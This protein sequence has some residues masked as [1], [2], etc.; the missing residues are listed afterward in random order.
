VSQE[1]DQDRSEQA[2]PHKLEEARKRGQVARSGD[3]SSFAVLVVAMLA[4]QALAEPALQGLAA[5][6]ARGLA[7][8]AAAGEAAGAMRLIEQGLREGLLILASLLLAVAV[9]AV[10]IGLLQAGG[11]VF[12]TAAL[13]PDLARLNP[14]QGFQK[15]FSL[16]LLFEGGKSTLKLCALLGVAWV[17]LRALLP[18]ALQLLGLP[19]KALLFRAVQAAGGLTAKLC[20][21]LLVFVLI[22]LIFV[23]W[24]F[25]RQLRM[26]RR[27][28][29]DEHKHREG[30]P[31][32]RSRRRELRLQMLKTA[33]SVRQVASAQVVVTNPTHVAVALKYQ[34]GVT[35]APLVVAKGTGLVARQIR[36]AAQRAGV[37]I[38]HSPRLARGL[39]REV[40]QD[41]HVPEHW[42]PPVARVLVWLR[43]LHD[44]RQGLVA[45]GAA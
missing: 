34:H 37:P 29:L 35:P 40:A 11:L 30:D 5:L 16:R 2:T 43:S 38:V 27:E 25:L 32:I 4:C 24:D 45:K 39:Y 28:V 26:S 15:L 13:K 21:A 20:A 9:A 33:R 1:Q 23:R 19:A 36:R 42:Y 22:D 31:R 10:L 41:A 7:F 44:A 12:S 14:V 18:S 6:L 8:G 3:A 17:A